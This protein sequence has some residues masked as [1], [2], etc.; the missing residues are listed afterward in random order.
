MKQCLACSGLVPESLDSCPNCAV[1]PRGSVLK[2]VVAAAGLVALAGT[3]SGCPMPVYG[4]ACT[5]TNGCFGDCSATLS[6]GGARTN[7]PQDPCFGLDGG[8]P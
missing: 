8:T 1:T 3:V 4:I 7:D 6:D 2:K 5:A